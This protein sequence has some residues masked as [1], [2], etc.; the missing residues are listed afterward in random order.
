M[1]CPVCKGSEVG[2]KKATIERRFI[3]IGFVENSVN[4]RVLPGRLRYWLIKKQGD[5]TISVMAC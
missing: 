5:I 4:S 1:T 2:N 3:T